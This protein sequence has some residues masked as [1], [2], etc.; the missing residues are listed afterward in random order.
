MEARHLEPDLPLTLYRT[1]RLI[2]LL[3]RHCLRLGVLVILLTSPGRA[4]CGASASGIH[5]SYPSTAFS[6]P[7]CEP[8]SEP[9]RSYRPS[10]K[11]RKG[12]Q[13]RFHRVVNGP[14]TLMAYSSTAF[15]LPSAAQGTRRP[16]QMRAASSSG[17]HLASCS[18]QLMRT[19][20]G[21]QF[22]RGM[23]AT[24]WLHLQNAPLPDALCFAWMC[25]CTL[26]VCV[27]QYADWA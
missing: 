14:G 27:Y 22:L 5:R 18:S 9:S 21:S 12:I 16:L 25:R 26:M 17:R 2:S 15:Q 13:E 1:A 20:G 3:L 8:V 11:S 10:H 7:V 23:A 19:N 4:R 6:Y 24:I